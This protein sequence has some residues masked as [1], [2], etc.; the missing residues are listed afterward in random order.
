MTTKPLKFKSAFV[1]PELGPPIIQDGFLIHCAHR[2]MVPMDFLREHLDPKNRNS[3]PSD[4]VDELVEQYKFQGIRHPIIV[5][6]LSGIVKAGDGR[7]QAAERAGMTAFP[8]DFQPWDNEDAE[9]AFGVADNAIQSWS[10]LDLAG[11]NTD[12]S[13]LDGINFDLDRLAI[14]DFELEMADKDQKGDPDDVPKAKPPV[15]KRGEVYLLG[16]HRLMCGDSTCQVDVATLMGEEKARLWITDPPYGVAYRSNGAEEKHRDIENDAMPLSE[17]KIFWQKAAENALE[18][19]D[20]KASYY[21]FACQGG[22]QM[23]MMMS[24]SDAK[25]K[26]RH[27]LIWAKDQMVLGRCDYHY[28]HEPILY[29]WKLEG[30]HEWCSDRKQT[31]LLEFPRPKS[32]DLHPTMKPVELVAYLL[33]NST[34]KGANVLD[35]FLGSGTTLIAREQANRKCFGMEIDP[36]YCG[37]ILDRWAKFTGL[38]P[39]REDGIAWSDIKANLLS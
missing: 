25:W 6:T 30:T 14:R 11:I 19:C 8:V 10:V 13:A 12:L 2:A 26:V 20:D 9:Y 31:S 32:S 33:S 1:I 22:D 18:A 16:N 34:R 23:M 7:F 15:V 36:I 4:Q 29:G 37:V 39:H 5:S 24:I 3:H 28:K 35:T 17:M 21:W 27:E 38:D